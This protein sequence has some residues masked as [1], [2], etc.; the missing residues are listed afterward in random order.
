[1]R[2]TFKDHALL[3]LAALAD[4]LDARMGY[5]DA[6]ALLSDAQAFTATAVSTN[7]YDT[8][9]ATND[10]GVGEP[11][12]I[13]FSV[14]VAADF[15]TGNETYQFDI[16]SSAAAN[17]GTPTVLASRAIVAGTLV[18]GFKF[19]MQVPPGKT[20]RYLG[21]Q[22]TAGGTTPLITVTASIKPISMMETLKYYPKNYT[23]S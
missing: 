5:V 16:I 3:A 18:A 22:L 6:Q 14:D 2:Y 15:T 1:M 9:S 17:L 23:I 4:K 21:W 12:G 10:I 19:F 13:E 8:L 11:L 20:Q 7:T